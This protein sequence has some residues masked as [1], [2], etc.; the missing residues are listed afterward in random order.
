LRDT[1][2]RTALEK[3]VGARMRY[4][5]PN[6]ISMPEYQPTLEGV[7]AISKYYWAIFS[8]QNLSR[9]E[10]QI[11]EVFE[12]EETIV[13]LGSFRLEYTDAKGGEALSRRGSIGTSGRVRRTAA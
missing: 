2:I 8:R 12:L 6:A 4:Y 7:D 9:F 3:D 1:F 10:R 13:E 11:G 5:L